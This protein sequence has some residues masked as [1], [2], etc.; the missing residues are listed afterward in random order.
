[1]LQLGGGVIE[2]EALKD[3]I[4][5]ALLVLDGCSSSRGLEGWTDTGVVTSELLRLGALGCVVTQLPIRNDPI[6]GRIFWEKFYG[7]LRTGKV[8]IGQALLLARRELKRCLEDYRLP[9]P[10]WAFYQLVGNPGVQLLG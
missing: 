1:V 2:I 8:T 3:Y 9:N 7:E 4:D 5:Q 10:A 6:V